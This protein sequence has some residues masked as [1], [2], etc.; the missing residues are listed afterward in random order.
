MST[1]AQKAERVKAAR[2]LKTVPRSAKHRSWCYFLTGDESWLYDTMN[3]DR[4][5][6]PGGAEAPIQS[7][8]TI[9]SPKRMLTVFR[10]PLE[11]SVAKILPK[12]QHF[13]AQYFLSTLLSVIA[14]NRLLST[15]KD[16]SRKIV[17]QFNTASPQ[18]ARSVIRY[19]NRD[20]LV[21]APHPPFSPDL[22]PHTFIHSARPKRH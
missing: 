11:F 2:E 13:D 8:Q 3:C 12:G 17:L 9:A 14:E 5:C 1:L 19:V 22:A 20:C 7:N 6:L 16:Q 4:M 10:P 15:W 21:R 18:T